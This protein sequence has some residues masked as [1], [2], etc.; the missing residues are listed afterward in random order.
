M[1]LL[2]ALGYPYDNLMI[3]LMKRARKI[4][5]KCTALMTPLALRLL[6]I[7]VIKELW[8]GGEAI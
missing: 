6:L 7:N 5:A 2:G 3:S 1:A 4:I 8:A